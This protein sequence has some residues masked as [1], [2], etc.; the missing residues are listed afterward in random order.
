MS[1]VDSNNLIVFMSQIIS[2]EAVSRH[3]AGTFSTVSLSL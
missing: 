2:I 1:D 3:V